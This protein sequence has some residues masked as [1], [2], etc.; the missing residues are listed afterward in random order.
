VRVRLYG[1]AAD[2]KQARRQSAQVTRLLQRFHA[3]RL[4]AKIPR[5]R[6]WR[7]TLKGQLAWSAAVKYHDQD[8]PETYAATAA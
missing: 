8:Y 7:L 3:R 5:S 1:V 2:P 4:I 6:R